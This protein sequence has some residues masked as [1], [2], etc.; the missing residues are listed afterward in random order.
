MEASPAIPPPC[1]FER[2]GKL[3]KYDES[4]SSEYHHPSCDLLV[5][6]DQRDMWRNA[7]TDWVATPGYLCIGEI[8]NFL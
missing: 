2:L 1:S 3:I 7:G 5:Y 8:P 4:M 6:I